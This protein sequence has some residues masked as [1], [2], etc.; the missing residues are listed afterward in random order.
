M[1][2]EAIELCVDI[3]VRERAPENASYTAFVDVS[4]GIND[5]FALAIGHC[6]DDR[7]TVLD[8]I[9]VATPQV[10]V[11]LIPAAVMERFARTLARYGCFTV[12]GD[13]YGK[14]WVV[15]AFNAYGISYEPPRRKD[16]EAKMSASELYLEAVPL[17]NSRSVRLLDHPGLIDQLCQLERNI[18][19]SG[20]ERVTHP[21]RGHDD[22]AN[23]A[24]GALVMARQRGV[25]VPIHRLQS[26][27]IGV[28]DPLAT[29][30]ENALAQAI[31]ES[32]AGRFTGPG[33]APTWH[34]DQNTS[35]AYGGD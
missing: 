4:G 19:A 31:A 20:R 12:Y 28:H 7:N 21:D 22:I 14:Q 8:C 11:P 1:T 33:H 17:I 30:E 34:G 13:D 29:A 27:G 24:C 6:P 2:R 15:E 35:E 18:V 25:G 10:G 32:R 3:D 16:A 9:D 26:Y 5:A 23:A